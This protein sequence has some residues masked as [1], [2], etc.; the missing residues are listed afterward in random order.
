MATAPPRP[1]VGVPCDVRTVGINPFHMVGEKYLTALLGVSDVVPL[2]IPSLAEEL[3][4]EECMEHFDGLLF[5]GSPSNVHP[6]Q[7]G[8]EPSREGTLHDPQRDAIALPLIQRCL[9]RGMPL[10]ALCRGFQELNVALGGTL[11]QLV[12]EVPGLLD[13][14]EDK[15]K[16]R[17]VQYG[18][19]HPVRL[20]EGGAF[21]RLVGVR[22][23]MVNSLHTQGIERLAPGLAAEAVAPDGLIEGVRVK[24]AAAFALGVQWHPEWKIV[25][26][27][28]PFALALF[29]AFGEAC[30]AHQEARRALGGRAGKVVSA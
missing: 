13:H 20:S 10:L 30:R 29:R 4:A 18:P 3:S 6:Q 7:Y 5:T 14:R 8:G 15:T 1:L 9:E 2:P 25:E 17:D 27:Q 28:D 23:I 16:P 22:E 24:D 19:A 26:L 11:H 12:H 21:E